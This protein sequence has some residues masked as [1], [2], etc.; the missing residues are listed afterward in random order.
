MS[1]KVRTRDK[2]DRAAITFFFFSDFVG[3]KTSSPVESFRNR[4]FS[5]PPTQSQVSRHIFWFQRSQFDQSGLLFP[6]QSSR[7]RSLTA[8]N[9]T[10]SARSTPNCFR[11]RKLSM[12]GGNGMSPWFTALNIQH[13][14]SESLLLGKPAGWVLRAPFHTKH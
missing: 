9:L 4:R 7:T 11:M 6:P 2:V 12:Y 14:V 1:E 3:G 5:R 8:S 10:S 13:K